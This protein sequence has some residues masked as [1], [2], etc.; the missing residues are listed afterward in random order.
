MNK[1]LFLAHDPGGYDAVSPVADV[2]WR[3]GE[4]CAFYC[5]GPAARLN[6]RYAVH[7][8]QCQREIENQIA[9][10][11]VR[12]LVTG[13]SWN[14]DFE[15][16][17]IEKCRENGVAAISILDYWSNYKMRFTRADGSVVFPDLYLVMDELAKQEAIQD[18][19]PESIL[20]IVGHPR[21]DQFVQ[22]QPEKNVSSLDIAQRK[23]IVFLSQP[24]SSL[25]GD[26]LGYTE[27]VAAD[28]CMRAARELGFA[29][30]VKF[31]PK[32]AAWFKGKYERYEIKETLP[33]LA[34]RH[35]CVG[36]STMALLHIALLGGLAISYQPGMKGKDGCI[37]NK[38]GMTKRIATWDNLLEYLKNPPEINMFS[39]RAYLWM[40]GKSV[41]RVVSLIRSI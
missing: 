34:A 11:T 21:L 29:F 39:S 5:I 28:G 10:G 7:E 20:R 24:L 6:A 13:T 9:G 3:Q 15:L 19:V 32:D 12:A 2:F 17:M 33:Q 35:L 25:Y 27:D 14:S 41:E 4:N 16:E 38:L 8:A 1:I 22:G 36:M 18:G 30:Y 23:S 31:H 40:D 37:T 26:S